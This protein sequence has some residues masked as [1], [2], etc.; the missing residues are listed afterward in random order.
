MPLGIKYNEKVK[1]V[2][3]VFLFILLL[4]VF[5]IRQIT[6]GTDRRT[7]SVEIFVFE[8]LDADGK[9]SRDE[10]PLPNTLILVT[11]NIHGNFSQSTLFTDDDGKTTIEAEYTHCFDLHALTPCGYI[12]T[13]LTL[14]SVLDG[15]KHQF[16]FQPVD[17]KT[18]SPS[19]RSLVFA[20]WRDINRD[21]I[22]QPTE[23]ALSGVNLA[24]APALGNNPVNDFYENEFSATT[25]EKG[26]ATLN[27]GN[28][29][30]RLE[31][32]PVTGWDTTIFKLEY[33]QNENRTLVFDYD[34]NTPKIRWGLSKYESLSLRIGNAYDSEGMGEWVIHL[35]A[36]GTFSARHNLQ[37]TTTKYG[38]YNLTEEAQE[39]WSLVAA[40]N[41]E[42]FSR[43]FERPGIPDETA[44]EFSLHTV[45]QVY[46][47]EAV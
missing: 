42:S 7:R 27:V 22:R 41:I 16:I 30:G 31:A 15:K 19:T 13:T 38:P 35:Y 25:D 4:G 1:I 8:D 36:D 21:G 43:T 28:S 47:S 9:R 3:L 17:G 20:L 12:N 40:A 23:P 37:D 10:A 46:L 44:Y 26:E 34:E 29:C 18:A 11:T 5:T 2:G 24:F 33:E 32:A 45:N 14:I 6:P 39:L